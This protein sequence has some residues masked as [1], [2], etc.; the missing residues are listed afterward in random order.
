MSKTGQ[1]EF[2]AVEERLKSFG[3]LILKTSVAGKNSY[4]WQQSIYLSLL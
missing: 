2:S 4:F 3:S 1:L